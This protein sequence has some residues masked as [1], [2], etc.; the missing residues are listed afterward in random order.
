[1]GYLLEK[2]VKAKEQNFGIYFFATHTH[3][4]HFSR[5]GQNPVFLNEGMKRA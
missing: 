3:H 1:M 4:K 5:F 2:H